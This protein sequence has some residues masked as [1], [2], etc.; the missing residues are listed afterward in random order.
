MGFKNRC[1][2]GKVYK[3]EREKR[4]MCRITVRFTEKTGEGQS[5]QKEMAGY[6]KQ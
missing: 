1:F 3:G 5:C 6:E 2:S 4:K